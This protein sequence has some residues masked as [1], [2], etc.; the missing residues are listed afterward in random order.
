MTTNKQDELYE[1][2]TRMIIENKVSQ[3]WR[4]IYSRPFKSKQLCKVVL[5]TKWGDEITMTD[6]AKQ[7][8]LINI[9]KYYEV[10]SFSDVKREI[11][12]LINQQV[13][14]T[15]A[16]VKRKTALRPGVTLSAI[17]EVERKYKNANI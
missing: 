14:A 9:L 16:E 10:E 1:A 4:A 6:K 8:E 3:I 13:L 7:E 11:S 5:V 2:V 17:E 12:H 15:L